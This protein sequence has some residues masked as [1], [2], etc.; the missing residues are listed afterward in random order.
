MKQLNTLLGLV[1]STVLVASVFNVQAAELV[2]ITPIDQNELKQTVKM[3]LSRSFN[4]TKLALLKDTTK[5]DSLIVKQV[6]DKKLSK[7][8]IAKVSHIAE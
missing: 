8:I 3:E 1:A 7:Q 5:V 4:E 2:K 6:S